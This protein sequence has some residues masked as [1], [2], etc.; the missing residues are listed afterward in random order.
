M[1]YALMQLKEAQW[2]L[3]GSTGQLWNHKGIKQL[4]K[5]YKR[6]RVVEEKLVNLH[7]LMSKCKH[8]LGYNV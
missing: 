1:F 6:L 5:D 8:C 7:D 2:E 4:T 3:L